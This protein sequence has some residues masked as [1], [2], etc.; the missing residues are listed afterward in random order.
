MT[1]TPTQPDGQ[2]PRSWA[3]SDSK[4]LLNEY[5]A[6]GDRR[7]IPVGS[8]MGCGRHRSLEV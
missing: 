5:S 2:T 3:G 8:E 6:V 7:A 4:S 1:S